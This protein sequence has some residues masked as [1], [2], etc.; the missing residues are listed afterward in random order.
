MS[1]TAGGLA[2]SDELAH[3][4][5]NSFTDGFPMLIAYVNA[6]SQARLSFRG[7]MHAHSADQLAFWARDPEG[8]ITQAIAT[9]PK[10]TVMYRDP[11]SRTTIFFYGRA[12]VVTD[13][14]TRD[15]CYNESP[16][17]EQK[18]DAEKKGHGVVID[19]DVVQGRTP[20][21]PINLSRA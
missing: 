7:S 3:R 4:I 15:R 19:L 1:D 18:A 10:V 21:G 16:E 6:D 5:S 14:A 2:L 8:G 17:A 13:D 12:H 9:N 11:T 20:D